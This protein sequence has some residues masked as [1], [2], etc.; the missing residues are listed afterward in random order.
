MSDIV[1][2]IC[3]LMSDMSVIDGMRCVYI[4]CVVADSKYQ[5]IRTTQV[6]EM[7]EQMLQNNDARKTAHKVKRN[8]KL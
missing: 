2:N 8:V 6:D 5:F 1:C 4:L 3:H 7:A